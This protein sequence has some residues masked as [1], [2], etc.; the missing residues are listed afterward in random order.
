MQIFTEI[1]LPELVSTVVLL[2]SVRGGQ[3]KTLVCD[4]VCHQNSH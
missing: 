3:V 1:H 4:G 2:H